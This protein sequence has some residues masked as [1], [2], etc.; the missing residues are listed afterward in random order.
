M[1]AIKRAFDHV[2]RAATARLDLLVALFGVDRDE[3][4]DAVHQRVAQAGFDR[5]GVLGGAAPGQLGAVVLG[6]ALDLFGD[7]QQALGRGQ[8]GVFAVLEHRLA[9]EH[10]VFDQ[11][12]QLG[13]QV[14][15]HAD[16]AGVDD[17]H[18]HARLDGVVQEHGV[19]G[20]AHRLVATE[21]E[22]H[23]RDAARHLGAR[24]VLLDP[25]RGVDEVHGV[26]VVLFDAGGNGKDVRVEDDVFGR[27]AHLVHEDA[28]GALA[29]LGLALIG[30]G[31]TLFVKGHHHG[32]R[33]IALDQLGLVQEVLD[34]FFQR[35]RVDDALALDALQARF[36]HV[37]FGRVDHDGHARNFRLAGDQ[38][39]E[40]HHG[41]L[42]VQHGLVHVDVDDLGAVFHLLARH[43]ESVLKAAFQDHARKGLRA[44]HVGA[45]AHV[46]EQRARAD[47]HWLQ[48]GQAHGR[49]SG[50]S[51]TAR[52]TATPKRGG[53]PEAG[54]HQ[55][56]AQHTHTQSG[57][58]IHG[59]ARPLWAMLRAAF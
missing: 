3:V 44:R 1:P 58:L 18:V 22:R 17:A 46:D 25:A 2:Q 10:D 51:V 40:A 29:D 13:V 43:R 12:A 23:V 24:Q 55:N 4:G 39:Q 33:A 37:P 15:V 21:A 26:V 48:A 42:A 6:R 47:V 54:H 34:A 57:I 9:V 49:H 11:L 36:D 16:H 7:A 14:V 50:G 52:C 38:V 8:A 28:V 5:G 35:D 41:G 59:F 30:V 45:L 32:G 27:E 56:D 19:D 20:L 53:K 31:L